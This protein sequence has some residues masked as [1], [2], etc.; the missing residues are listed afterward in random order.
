MSLKDWIYSS[1][2]NPAI[3]GQWGLLHILT[4]LLSIAT[5]IILSIL[6]HKKSEKARKI[7]MYNTKNNQF[8]PN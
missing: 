5:I 2:P 3:K 4:L 6:F 8:K 7:L 1:Y